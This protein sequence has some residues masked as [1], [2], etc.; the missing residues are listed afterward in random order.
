MSIE[1]I[2]VGLIGAGGNTTKLHIPGLQAQDGVAIMSVANRTAASG[3]R[4]AD[5][6]NIPHVA[7]DWLEIIEDPEIDAICIGTWPYMHA[8]M[9]IAAL[10]AGRHVLCEARMALN[11]DEGHDMLAAS[12]RAPRQVAQ[13]V[14]APHTLAFDQTIIEMIG[15]GYIGD[16]ITL[17]ARIAQG[18]FPNPGSPITWRQDRDLSGNNIMSM[19]IW[20][21]AMMRWLGPMATLFAAGRAVVPHRVDET[22]RRVA[23]AIPDH[24]DI[25]GTMEQGGQVRF[26]VSTVLGHPPA[27]VDVCIF[28]TDGTLR[29]L[30]AGS[31]P[32]TLYAG[33]R[34]D[35]GLAPV[36]IDAAKKGGW[37]V[38]EEF[39]NAIRGLETISHTDFTTAVKYMEWTDA[40]TESLR[41]GQS[42]SLL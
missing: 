31:D 36:A 4:V 12:R 40:V 38:E 6:F 11:A 37:R 8:P 19:G 3:Q 2:R 42:V 16:L 7:T 35:G 23:M 34:G 25:M 27:A 15:A 13:I 24:L 10:E 22:G 17:D 32:M 41:T 20:Y 14:P 21:E 5:E 33:K 26:N 29:L 18:D 39:I 9:T 30:Q 28:G 1:K